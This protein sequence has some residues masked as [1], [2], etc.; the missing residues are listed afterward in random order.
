L[1]SSANKDADSAVEV[2]HTEV[3]EAAKM[4]STRACAFVESVIESMGEQT[5]EKPATPPDGGIEKLEN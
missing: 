3:L 1:R 5:H 2:S 4:A